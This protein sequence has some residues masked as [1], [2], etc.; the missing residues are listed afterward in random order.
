MGTSYQYQPQDS[1]RI[2]VS[3]FSEVYPGMLVLKVPVVS[4]MHDDIKNP[5][6]V[7]SE[8]LMKSLG[9]KTGIPQ[10]R[11]NSVCRPPSHLNCNI[12]SY[13]VSSLLSQPFINFILLA[14]V[15]A[16]GLLFTSKCDCRKQMK[17]SI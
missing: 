5:C 1:A 14:V 2:T 6:K 8:N 17:D 4:Y 10:G 16:F 3:S 11:W 7:V 15:S 12:N 9:K 13:L